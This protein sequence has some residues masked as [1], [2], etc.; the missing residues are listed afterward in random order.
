MQGHLISGVRVGAE[1]LISQLW[2]VCIIA[3]VSGDCKERKGKLTK[4]SHCA[5]AGEGSGCRGGRFPVVRKEKC[6][7]LN[8]VAFWLKI[9][10]KMSKEVAGKNKKCRKEGFWLQTQRKYRGSR[11]VQSCK[12]TRA[13]TNVCN[14]RSWTG[15][16]LHG[17]FRKIPQEFHQIISNCAK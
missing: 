1:K 4:P 7:G 6:R 3:E 8:T 11:G 14:I 17:F 16:K 12:L 9:V 15:K 5:G 2:F 13:A 10:V